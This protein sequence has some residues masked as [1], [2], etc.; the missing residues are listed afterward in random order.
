MGKCI[1]AR[2]NVLVCIVVTAGFLLTAFLGYRANYSFS[3][4]EIENL[5]TLMSED[6]YHQQSSI[7]AKP[8][9]VSQTMADDVFLA[10]LLEQGI[11]ESDEER[12]G[13][14]V[15]RY[16]DSY[17]EAYDYESAF[18][19]SVKTSRYYSYG[20]YDRTL[21][22]GDPEN[23]W[24][25]EALAS[26]EDYV[27]EVD[28]DQVTDDEITVFVNCRVLSDE[29]ELFGI[30]GVGMRTG[31]LQ[32]VLAE[33]GDTFDANVF[34]ISQDGIIQL[35]KDHVGYD[36]VNLFDLYPYDE[37]VRAKV[38]GGRGT[39]SS[40]GFWVSSA[41]GGP[42]DSYMVVRALP[43][44]D[45]RLVVERDT[46]DLTASL[47]QRFVESVCIIAAII[48]LILGIITHAIHTFKRRIVE[49][50][51]QADAERRTAFERATEDLFEHIYELD[52]TNNRPANAVTEQ[53]FES[54]GAPKGMPFDKA[55]EIV[56]EAQI[57]E[58]YRQGYID[59]FK[60]SSVMKALAEGR[61]T[62]QYEFLMT[63]DAG[64]YY[65]VR[66]TARIIRLGN[67][68]T[69]HMLSYRQNIDAEKRQE[70]KMIERAE[71]DE[72][73]GFASKSATTRHVDA[74]IAEK[75]ASRFALYMIDID[76]FKEAND[77]Y[78]HKFGDSVIIAFCA[79][80]REQFGEKAVLGRVGGDEFT[81]FV[82]IPSEAWAEAKAATLVKALDTTYESGGA[83]WKMSTSIGVA[84][85]P[86]DGSDF[87]VLVS[88][89][90][91]AMYE[92][93]RL[94]KNRFVMFGRIETGEAANPA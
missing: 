34:L 87:S 59:T 6:I 30:V 82:D 13:E 16:L 46:G 12:F 85:Y 43:D 47:Q 94:G 61:E 56:A 28:N 73:T 79:I 65:W 2:T 4:H 91:T 41:S 11:E 48:V 45:W 25:F 75:P 88:D 40:E 33:Y 27:L 22:E 37:E 51:Q 57:K 31:V 15:S 26:E 69:V 18:L 90:D 8:I 35:S 76:N 38:L 53:Y 70:R 63:E 44:L 86:G 74:M 66:I 7:F 10:D 67:E 68:G 93:K 80:V 50:T 60:P 9:A 62:L 83:A 21:V 39:E 14:E 20:G 49:V 92:A 17:H 72:M 32:D 52:I 54:L 5:S 24:Y 71:T 23:G 84:V 78:G 1:L 29:G 77:E 55:L 89:A 81:A 19:V 42:V 64:E 3:T 36:A 58:E